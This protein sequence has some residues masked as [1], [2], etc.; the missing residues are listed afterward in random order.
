MAYR[1]VFR[2]TPPN[3]DNEFIHEGR[4][5]KPGWAELAR[6][7]NAMTLTVREDFTSVEVWHDG[8]RLQEIARDD[9]IA[10]VC[11]YNR[12]TTL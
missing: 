4:T 1:I 12:Q 6:A 5:G 3:V 11:Y 10:T 2:R 9:A 8:K 7:Y